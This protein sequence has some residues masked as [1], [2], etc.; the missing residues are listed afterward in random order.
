LPSRNTKFRD[1][2]EILNVNHSATPAQIK[3]AFMRKAMKLHPDKRRNTATEV[4]RTGASCSE[5]V[6]EMLVQKQWAEASAAYAIIGKTDSREYYDKSLPLRHLIVCFY[7][8]HNPGFLSPDRIDLAIKQFGQRQMDLIGVLI[9]RYQLPSVI[10]GG[11]EMKSEADIVQFWEG[12]RAAAHQRILIMRQIEYMTDCAIVMQSLWRRARAR[13][14]AVKLRK[15]KKLT[16]ERDFLKQKVVMEQEEK[17]I[18]ERKKEAGFSVAKTPA[19]SGEHQHRRQRL[20]QSS[21]EIKDERAQIMM[22]TKHERERLKEERKL[23]LKQELRARLQVAADKKSQEGQAEREAEIN[24]RLASQEKEVQLR[25]A[26]RLIENQSRVVRELSEADN[27]MNRARLEER[28]RETAKQIEI[29]E[30]K[31]R[32]ATKIASVWRQKMAMDERREREAER[33][34]E[35]S[36]VS[37][38]GSPFSFRSCSVGQPAESKRVQKEV[39]ARQMRHRRNE[40]KK[41][42]P[43]ASIRGSKPPRKVGGVQAS[44]LEMAQAPASPP[45][46]PPHSPSP[47]AVRQVRGG[48]QMGF[49]RGAVSSPTYQRDNKNG[50]S[51][52]LSAWGNRK[53]NSTQSNYQ[54]RGNPRGNPRAR[55]RGPDTT[56]D[57]RASHKQLMH[58]SKMH[59]HGSRITHRSLRQDHQ[60]QAVASSNDERLPYRSTG[61]P[62]AHAPMQV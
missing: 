48:Q 1:N 39:L 17:K 14:L 4:Q 15:M 19:L 40:R 23:Y 42:L 2:Y 36:V 56:L 45:G 41:A 8:R 3:K 58:G 28:A 37:C 31:E 47:R 46:S 51:P 22:Q 60:R 61:T 12:H 53:N 35:C 18:Q 57:P 55:T 21:V 20:E 32:N 38:V 26:Q 54:S 33:M 52:P 49:K 24:A 5:V 34:Q 7:L 29:Y 25:A 44:F 9:K 10:L 6:D 62:R 59:S 16:A 11:I 43:P 30:W 13:E 27:Q 50:M